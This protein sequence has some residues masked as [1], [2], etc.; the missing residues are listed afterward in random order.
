MD[1]SVVIVVDEPGI[2]ERQPGETA[3]Q[4]NA[5]CHYRDLPPA[6]RSIDKAYRVWKGLPED[7]TTRAVRRWFAWSS[8]NSW[9]ERAA[10]YD[11]ATEQAARANRQTEHLL[12]I[13]AY[14]AKLVGLAKETAESAEKMLRIIN[15]N[16]TLMIAEAEAAPE[17]AMLTVGQLPIWVRA[18]T[19]ALQKAMDAWAMGLGVEALSLLLEQQEQAQRASEDLSV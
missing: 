4:Y 5:F 9:P 8:G 16:L 3:A 12:E 14:Q 18:M 2:W 13:D 6:A 17:K 1:E 10:A 19:D 11:V 7:D 15:N